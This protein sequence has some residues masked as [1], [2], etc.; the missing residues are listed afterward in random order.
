MLARKI[1]RKIMETRN[2]T[3]DNYEDGSVASTSLPQPTQLTWK[4]LE[5][6]REKWLC[7]SCDRKYT[8]GH[9]CVEKKLI[10]INCEE[11]EENQ[12]EISKGDNIHQEPT[13]N[14]E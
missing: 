3:T 10:Y 5:E 6:H 12:Q 2:P 4:K 7:Y 8:K 11:E 1:E 9:K 13:P 14:K